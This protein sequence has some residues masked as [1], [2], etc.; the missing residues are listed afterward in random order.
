VKPCDIGKNNSESLNAKLTLRKRDWDSGQRSKSMTEEQ[1][2]RMVSNA[3]R[4]FQRA[5]ANNPDVKWSGPQQEEQQNDY[6]EES[7]GQT[8]GASD[9]DNQTGV[10]DSL[11]GDHGLFEVTIDFRFS[12]RRRR[13]LDGML[14]TILDCLV[15][16][17]RR[18][19]DPH[20]EDPGASEPMRPRRRKRKD[21]HPKIDVSGK[22]PF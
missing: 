8:V 18:C 10:S 9:P 12:D 6:H 13:D 4:S 14:S 7:E 15:H 16:A 3:N 11:G 1:F 5:N 20:T 22:L 21:Q 2:R 17:R 19:L